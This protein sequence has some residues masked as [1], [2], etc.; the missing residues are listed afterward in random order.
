MFDEMRDSDGGVRAPYQRIEA[1]LQSAGV[2]ALAGRHAEAEALF[3]RIGITFAV[4]AEDGGDPERLIPFDLIPR[5]F[6][7]AEWRTLQRG[8]R[9][10]AQALNAFLYDV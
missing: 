5:V 8:I 6:S 3:R 4:Y 10:R 7:A 1:W 2:G 9:Q